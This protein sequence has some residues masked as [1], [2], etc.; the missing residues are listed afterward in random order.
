MKTEHT[1]LASKFVLFDLLSPSHLTSGRKRRDRPTSLMRPRRQ[2]ALFATHGPRP[3]RK[4]VFTRDSVSSNDERVNTRE[5]ALDSAEWPHL[6]FTRSHKN[7]LRL[8]LTHSSPALTW[9]GPS[10]PLPGCG[11]DIQQE[12]LALPP[13]LSVFPSRLSKRYSNGHVV[14][15]LFQM[16]GVDFGRSFAAQQVRS[17]RNRVANC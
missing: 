11:G 5:R 6:H 3:G 17:G 8:E 2:D 16:S 10:S 14:F 4:M 9:P 13:R 15:T 1:A 12:E 7:T